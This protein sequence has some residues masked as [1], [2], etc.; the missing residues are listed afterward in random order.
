MKSI[1]IPP[2][3]FLTPAQLSDRWL[4]HPETIR[5]KLREGQIRALTI[6]RRRLIPI[7]EVEKIENES[8]S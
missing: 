3:K 6:G 2:V 5:R 8:F 4:F 1:P 7:E